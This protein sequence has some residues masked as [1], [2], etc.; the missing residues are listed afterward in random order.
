[1]LNRRPRDC[2]VCGKPLGS[3]NDRLDEFGFPV[4]TECYTKLIE[5]KLAPTRSDP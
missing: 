1:V 3:D 4:H 5:K 2:W